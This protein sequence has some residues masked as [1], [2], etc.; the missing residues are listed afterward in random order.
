MWI[1]ISWSGKKSQKAAE[2]LKK[3]LKLLYSKFN[4]FV[5]SEDIMIGSFWHEELQNALKKSNCGILCLTR[6]NYAEPWLLYEAGA[7]SKLGKAVVPFLINVDKS[8]IPDPL[9]QLQS[10][11]FN[12]DEIRRMVLDF[13]NF[14]Q[15]DEP[16]WREIISGRFDTFYP[17]LEKSLHELAS[18]SVPQK[19]APD[20][21]QM[22]CESLETARTN[23]KNIEAILQM[24]T[25]Q[26]ENIQAILQMQA[27][28]SQD[29]AILKRKMERQLGMLSRNSL[30][31]SVENFRSTL[32]GLQGFAQESYYE[33]G[34]SVWKLLISRNFTKAKAELSLF[35]SNLKDWMARYKVEAAT[36]PPEAKKVANVM[37]ALLISIADIRR[38]LERASK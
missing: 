37:S 38:E 4:P 26:R 29:I 33:K 23:A 19:D 12:K 21:A 10:V 24:Q 16:E 22:L 1:F 2:I 5:S 32:C 6:E 17:Q 3:W 25:Q 27:Q 34:L 15:N 36:Y 8:V 13:G 28:Q 35:E 9:R 31:R 14:C 18:D 20:G 30:Q 11:T 7:L